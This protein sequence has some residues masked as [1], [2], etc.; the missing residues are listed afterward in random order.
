VRAILFDLDGTLLDLDLEAFLDRYFAELETAATP[1]ARHSETT[2]DIMSALHRATSAMMA[3]HPG[4]TN[5]ETFYAEF[6]NRTGVDLN[7]HWGV[8]DAFY[9]DVFPGLRDTARPA[10]GAREV[11]SVA[12][13]LGL[14]MAVATN[15]IFP[16][17][18]VEH[19]IAWA[20]LADVRFDLVTSYEQMVACKPHPAYY[21]QVASLLEVD[22]SDCLMVGDDHVLDMAAADIGMK[23]YY[24]GSRE[25]VAADIAGDLTALAELLPRLT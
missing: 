5:R 15:P 20:G 19:R 17:E 1:L 11:V 18:A 16:R 4:T 7:M 6:S 12:Q 10:P 22:P 13:E 25:G 21:R 8:F 14:R 23:T 9:R 2:V 24:V 3:E